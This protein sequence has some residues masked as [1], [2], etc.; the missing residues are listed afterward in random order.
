MD[1]SLVTPTL[2]TTMIGDL[3]QELQQHQVTSADSFRSPHYHTKVIKCRPAR[4]EQPWLRTIAQ[5]L[6]INVNTVNKYVR[7]PAPPAKQRRTT[8]KLIGH[9]EV[10]Y[11]RW[12]EANAVQDLLAE[13]R[14]HGFRGSYQTSRTMSP[15]ARATA[16]AQAAAAPSAPRYD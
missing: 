2:S 5:Q 15:N 14:Q 1:P 9:E 3:T 7:M 13:L 4:T 6:Q 8:R 16:A 10:L 12:D 11:R